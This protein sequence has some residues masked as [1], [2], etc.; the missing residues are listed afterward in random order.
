MVNSVVISNNQHFPITGSFTTFQ[1]SSL[2]V[3]LNAGKNT[4][5]MFNIAS[6]SRVRAAPM[7]VWPGGGISCGGVPSTPAGLN[8]QAVST[9]Q[10]TLSWSGSIAPAGCTVGS[11]SVFRSTTAG[12]TPSGANQIATGLTTTMYDDTTALCGTTYYYVVE[13]I[14]S[15]GPS[16]PSIQASVT[17]SG[18]PATGG[19]RI[20]CG[21]PA[22][23]PFI[24]DTDFAGGGTINHANT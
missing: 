7:T 9:S 5:Q 22:V 21:G 3:P 19:L 2:V 16:G 18:C 23:D 12:F 17:T 14:D 4:I 13:A 10:I 1:N 20:N 6:A 8:A 15:A 11:Y 24:A